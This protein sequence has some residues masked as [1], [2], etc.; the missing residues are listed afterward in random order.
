MKANV[1]QWKEDSAEGRIRGKQ[2]T[3]VRNR[4]HCQRTL[5]YPIQNRLQDHRE[6]PLR[7]NR[8]HSFTKLINICLHWF[9]Y[10]LIPQADNSKKINGIRSQNDLFWV[11]LENPLIQRNWTNTSKRRT[12][13]PSPSS[14]SRSPNTA[15]SWTTSWTSPVSTEWSLKSSSCRSSTRI[16]PMTPQTSA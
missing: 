2:R 4:Q 9:K 7:G 3:R 13:L 5:L 8:I 1:L 15:H 16:D 14:F 10:T 11:P 12:A 6:S